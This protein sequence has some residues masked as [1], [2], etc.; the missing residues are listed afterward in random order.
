MTDKEIEMLKAEIKAEVIKDLTGQAP[1]TGNA[2]YGPLAEVRKKYASCNGPLYKK[3]GPYKYH[4]AWIAINK[5]AKLMTGEK[6]VSSLTLSKEIEYAE[7]CDF[8]CRY[9][10]GE[11]ED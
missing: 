3:L 2:A 4:Q 5:I 8:L 9:V 7:I 1:R 11:V 10:M 6:Y